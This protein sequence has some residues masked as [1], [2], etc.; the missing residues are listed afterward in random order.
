MCASCETYRF[1]SI[2]G[3]SGSR[4]GGQQTKSTE[5]ART[6]VGVR[7]GRRRTANKKTT[8]V[9]DVWVSVRVGKQ[10]APGTKHPQQHATPEPQHGSHIGLNLKVHPPVQAN[11]WVNSLI[12]EPHGSKITLV[13]DLA[14]APPLTPHFTK[15]RGCREFTFWVH[16]C[17]N[18][19]LGGT[20]V[21]PGFQN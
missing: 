15:L 9:T 14:P 6:R 8:N 7:V 19:V 18:I 16:P 4:G 21:D 2:F 5:A 11:A 12:S 3:V 13:F 17:F 20:G 1:C 10:P